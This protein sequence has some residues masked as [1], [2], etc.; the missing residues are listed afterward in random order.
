MALIK[1]PIETEEGQDI[2]TKYPLLSF[3]KQIFVDSFEKDALVIMAKYV[4]FF[5]LL[6]SIYVGIVL[7]I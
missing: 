3:E 7:F 2:E 4:N 5:P 1:D 6:F